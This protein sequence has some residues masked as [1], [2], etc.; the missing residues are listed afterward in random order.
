[1]LVTEVDDP[2]GVGHSAYNGPGDGEA[3]G[4]QL[5]L[6]DGVRLQGESQLDTDSPRG[7]GRA[8]YHQQLLSRY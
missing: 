7:L 1:M 2:L 6:V 4:Q 5:E 3:P 8:D